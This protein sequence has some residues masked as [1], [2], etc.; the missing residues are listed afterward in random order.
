MSNEKGD[1]VTVFRI[2]KDGA[3]TEKNA[4]ELLME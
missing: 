3:E 1:R 4:L 2:T